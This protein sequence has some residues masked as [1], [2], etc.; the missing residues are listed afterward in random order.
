MPDSRATIADGQRRESFLAAAAPPIA[1]LPRK[2][3]RDVVNDIRQDIK[4]RYPPFRAYYRIRAL[5]YGWRRYPELPLIRHLA[6]RGR[7]SLDVG[8]NLGLYTYFLA[9]AS[10]HVYAFEPNPNPYRV[11]RSV[12]DSNVTV[13]AMALSDVSG[14]ADLVIPRGPRGWSNNGATLERQYAGPAMTVRVPCRRIDDLGIADIGFIKIDVE[15]YELAV[16]E[17]ARETLAR[18]RPALL[19][20][21]E[22]THRR[23]KFAAVFQLL[24]SLGYEGFFLETGVLRTLSHFSV[25]KHQIAPLA[26]GG[27]SRLYV[28]NFI[29]L[30]R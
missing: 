21:N 30:P 27:D 12:A 26:P 11:L 19:V 7:V 10:R 18:D 24:E 5:L 23:A 25:E 9:R 17:G 13:L 22:V 2:T 8:A 3:F 6:D 20:E 1:H 14:E 4:F 28:R 15:G 29:F 16:L